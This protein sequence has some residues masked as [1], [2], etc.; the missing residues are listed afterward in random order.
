MTALEKRRYTEAEYLALERVSDTKHEFYG[1]EIFERVGCTQAHVLIAG[2]V[3][4]RLGMQILERPCK[5]YGSLMQVKVQETG[6]H[7]YPDVSAVCEESEF[8]SPARVTL[9][10]PSLIVE[11]RSKSPPGYARE[12]KFRH[13][14]KMES[15]LEYVLISRHEAYVEYYRRQ[16]ENE[17]LA[18]FYSKL[19]DTFTLESIG[20][21]LELGQIYWKVTLEG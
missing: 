4:M 20:C 2:N 14:R 3:E 11:V 18:R 6:L 10:N 16:S 1:G 5:V 9:L 12:A 19:E 21:S 17:W 8:S 7:T 13:Y 15:L